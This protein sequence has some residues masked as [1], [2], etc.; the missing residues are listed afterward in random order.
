MGLFSTTNNDS[1]VEKNRR[2]SGQSSRRHNDDS[3]QPVHYG[4]EPRRNPIVGG[5]SYQKAPLF[6]QWIKAAAID[7]LT[8]AAFGALALGVSYHIPRTKNI[9]TSALDSLLLRHTLTHLSSTLS[10]QPTLVTSQSLS[11]M[12]RSFSHPSHIQSAD[13][14]SQSGPQP[15]SPFS[16]QCSSS[17]LC[18][19]ASSPSGTPTTLSSASYTPSS[20]LQLSRRSSNGSLVALLQTF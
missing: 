8:L 3:H 13:T 16:S 20:A 15:S 5:H 6:G 12:E 18:R 14:S 11:R 17:W 7:I 2:A 9:A 4:E 1:V 19:Y 10:V